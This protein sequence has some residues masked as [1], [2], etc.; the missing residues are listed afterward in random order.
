MPVAAAIGDGDSSTDVLEVPSMVARK[1][2]VAARG[3]CS[4]GGCD[5]AR[6]GFC[7]ATDARLFF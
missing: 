2:A 7:F 4:H 3:K 6:C 1:A 5:S